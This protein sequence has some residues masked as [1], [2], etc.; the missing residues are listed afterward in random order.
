[1]LLSKVLIMN[2]KLWVLDFNFC[3]G[4]TVLLKV[5]MS[6]L[7]KSDNINQKPWVLAPILSRTVGDS[8]HTNKG[9]AKFCLESGKMSQKS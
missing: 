4:I 5:S 7:M 6:F 3:Q 2:S 9:P 8:T 1:M